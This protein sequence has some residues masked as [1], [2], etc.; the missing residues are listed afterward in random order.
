MREMIFCETKKEID[1]FRHYTFMFPSGNPVF[2]VSLL[3][4]LN[5]EQYTKEVCYQNVCA[6]ISIVQEKD[7]DDIMFL[8][9]FWYKENNHTRKHWSMK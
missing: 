6:I 7:E 8:N 4:A 2:F 3:N 9:R 5:D 1:A